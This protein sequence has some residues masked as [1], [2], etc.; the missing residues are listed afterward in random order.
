MLIT[1]KV[2]HPGK[3]C[4]ETYDD[5]MR[6]FTVSF[7]QSPENVIRYINDRE[8]LH[9]FFVYAFSRL[10]EEHSSFKCEEGEILFPYP[11]SEMKIEKYDCYTGR[12]FKEKIYNMVVVILPYVEMSDGLYYRKL[13]FVYN[14]THD[15]L[16]AASISL[17]DDEIDHYYGITML[18]DNPTYIG[19]SGYHDGFFTVLSDEYKE[20]KHLPGKLEDLYAILC[21]IT[22]KEDPRSFSIVLSS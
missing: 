17:G 9:A 6:Q 13:C 5:L 20:L 2:Y 14:K 19:Y 22:G 8:N 3:E 16:H 4:Q 11:S 15:D 18:K 7:F 1:N 10:L 21:H 12:I